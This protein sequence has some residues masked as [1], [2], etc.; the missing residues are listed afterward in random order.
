MISPGAAG[1]SG[2]A[3]SAHSGT[4]DVGAIA[5]D[6]DGTLLDTVHE[7]AS[8]VNALLAEL[9][10]PP[11]EKKVVGA[12]IGKGMANLVRLALALATY[13][14]REGRPVHELGADGIVPTVAAL[15][16]RVRYVAPATK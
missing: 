15:A 14:Y 2:S 11:L 1:R 12:L 4:I 7:L 16:D 6:L 3:G 9:G 10:Y 5:F 13:G 8:A